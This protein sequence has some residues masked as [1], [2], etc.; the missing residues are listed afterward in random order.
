MPSVRFCLLIFISA[1][2][3]V[4]AQ[5]VVQHKGL[6]T[7][8]FA[9]AADV[10]SATA[11][12]SV[13]INGS[14]KGLARATTSCTKGSITAA[15]DN[16]TALALF[17]QSSTGVNW[18]TVDS[19]GVESGTCLLAICGVS[20]SGLLDLDLK[21]SG[22]VDG[23]WNLWGVVCIAGNTSQ[24]PGQLVKKHSSGA[25]AVPIYHAPCSAGIG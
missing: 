1:F 24:N 6:G 22:Y 14:S 18:T 25:A 19:C 7:S 23:T 13:H 8:G 11:V 12:C 17:Q 3:L 16:D 15:A 4:Q 20:G 2:L 21:V 5:Q 10:P 9:T